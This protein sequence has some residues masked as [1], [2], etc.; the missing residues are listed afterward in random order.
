MRGL[1]YV[2]GR[3]QD[4][5]SPPSPCDHLPVVKKT[6]VKVEVEGKEVGHMWVNTSVLKEAL[7]NA[8]H[9]SWWERLLNESGL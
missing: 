1:S 7:Y 3:A 5:E 6:L 8:Q 9:P 4:A 2:I